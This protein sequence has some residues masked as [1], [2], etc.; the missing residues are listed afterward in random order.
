MSLPSRLPALPEAKFTEHTVTILLVDDDEFSRDLLRHHLLK[1]GCRVLQACNGS[2]AIAR[3]SREHIDL[4][5]LDVRMP[6]LDGYQVLE[7]LKSGITTRDVPVIMITAV[8]DNASTVK[9]IQRGAEDYLPK[10]FDPVLLNARV[11]ACL[12]KKRLHDLEREYQ[13]SLEARVREQVALISS[14]HLAVIFAMSRLA[15]SKDPETGA[16]L[17]RMREYCRILSIELGSAS[18]HA[19]LI[20]QAFIDNIYAASPL[21]DIG[22]VGVPD[23]ILL[24][25]GKLSPEEWPIMQ[26]HTTLGAETLR[27]VDRQHPGNA[28]IRVGID[29]AECHHEKWDGSGYPHGLVGS[30]IPLAARILALGDVYDALTSRRCYKPAFSHVV[31][32]AYLLEQSGRHFDPEVVDAFLRCEDTFIRIRNSHQDPDDELINI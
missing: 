27:A 9:C 16:H 17:E 12:E 13:Q 6:G 29:I 18:S 21:H 22:K 30:A 14:S 11:S 24:K 20:D 2:E 5:L 15:E 1:P 3:I 19:A 26:T 28:F 32:R 7:I 23:Q 31:S 10:P 8:D 25:P 4:V